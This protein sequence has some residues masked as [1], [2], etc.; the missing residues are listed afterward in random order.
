MKNARLHISKLKLLRLGRFAEALESEEASLAI[1][2]E[3]EDL[4]GI[5]S[6]SSSL[7]FLFM[8]AGDYR[9]AKAHFEEGI[10]Y[11]HKVKNLWFGAQITSWHIT[12]AMAQGDYAEANRLGETA[13]AAC[14]EI[15][16]ENGT[17]NLLGVLI[18]SAWSE[19]DYAKLLDYSRQLA[20]KKSRLGEQTTAIFQARRAISQDDLEPA[21]ALLKK[22]VSLIQSS[23]L[24]GFGW[25]HLLHGWIALW[26]KQGRAEPAA[27]LLSALDWFYRR[28]APGLSPR[29]RSEHDANLAAARAG[30]GPEAFEQAWRAGQDMTMEQ[31]LAFIEQE[32]GL[33]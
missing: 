21:A 13:L 2:R 10:E 31:A 27:R 17:I 1:S 23:T 5:G 22:A 6:R 9:K 12:L 3:I 19:G 28:T 33:V 18:E 32:A 8:M 29:E 7:G 30:L 25:Q 16:Y 24:Y 14:R 11:F 20:G 26:M 15:Q 4:D